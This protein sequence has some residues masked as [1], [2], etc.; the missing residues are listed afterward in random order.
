MVVNGVGGLFGMWGV[1]VGG[2]W[3]AYRGF[4]GLLGGF[5]DFCGCGVSCLWVFFWEMT[6]NQRFSFC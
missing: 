3:G 6:T 1:V 4:G 5:G 2:V